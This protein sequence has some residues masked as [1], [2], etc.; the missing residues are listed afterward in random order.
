MIDACGRIV[1][2]NL[3]MVAYA[4]LSGESGVIAYRV[5]A[6]WIA[7][8]FEGGHEYLY[9]YARTGREHVERMIELARAGRGL[10]TY[11]SRVVQDRYAARLR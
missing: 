2:Q 3:M 8:T 9:N 7:V 4:N 1:R 6:D 11:I 10:S 5:G